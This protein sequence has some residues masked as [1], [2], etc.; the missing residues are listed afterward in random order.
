[1]HIVFFKTESLKY[2]RLYYAKMFEILKEAENYEQKLLLEGY[3]NEKI[4]ETSIKEGI[5]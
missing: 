1:M 3:N 4:I 2:R 5:K